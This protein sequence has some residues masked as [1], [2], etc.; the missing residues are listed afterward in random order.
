MAC[1]LIMPEKAEGVTCIYEK[2]GMKT[3]LCK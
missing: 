2:T 1:G 3:G